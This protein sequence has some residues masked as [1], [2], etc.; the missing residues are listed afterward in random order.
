LSLDYVRLYDFVPE[1]LEKLHNA[2]R[3]IYLLS[4]AQRIFTEPELKLL[5]IY[6]CFD[7]IVISSDEGCKK[8]SPR[9]YRAL[10]D[11]YSLDPKE[12]I[13]IGNDPDA[14]IKGA[15]SV[16]LDT[17]YIHSNISP[18]LKGE[19]NSTYSVMDGDVKKLRKLILK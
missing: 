7:G 4:N 19:V 14:D 13:M 6:D 17:L 15:Q 8:P 5:N 16:G 3:K 12:S 10:L 18:K 1:L 9:F 2:D 11:R